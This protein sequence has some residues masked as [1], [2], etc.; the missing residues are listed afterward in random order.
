MFCCIEF[1]GLISICRCKSIMKKCIFIG[2]VLAVSFPSGKAADT[3]QTAA[4]AF[5]SALGKFDDPASHAGAV[6]PTKKPVWDS[7]LS[8]GFS[9]TQGNSD[10]LLTTGAFKTRTKRTENEFMLGADGAYGESDSVKNNEMLHG[11]SQYN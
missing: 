3:N 4:L 10:T 11:V 8:A 9:L 5:L 6:A 2:L 7:S 1:P